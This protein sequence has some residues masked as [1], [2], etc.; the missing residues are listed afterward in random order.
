MCSKWC[1]TCACPAARRSMTAR[2][3]CSVSKAR[4]GTLDVMMPRCLTCFASHYASKRNDIGLIR[5]GVRKTAMSARERLGLYPPI[6]PYRQGRLKVGRGPR[7]LLRGMRQ[8]R[9]QA[10]ADRARRPRRRLQPHHAPLP[11]SVALP[12]HPV[13]P[14]RLRPLDA[15]R[16]P[17]GQHDLGP[18]RRHG[19]A[20]RAPRHRAL[21]AVRRLVGL[22]AGARLRPDASRRASAS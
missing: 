12:H 1:A 7:D 16:Q 3:G 13:R 10:G 9:R 5:H 20:A 21:A 15:A 18:G 2:C 8:P 11:R 22:D 4:N 14:A 19:A 6:E 17:R